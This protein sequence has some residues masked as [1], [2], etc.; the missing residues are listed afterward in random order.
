MGAYK[1]HMRTEHRKIYSQDLLNNLFKHPYTRIEYVVDELGVGRQAAGRYL[2]Q[3]AETGLIEKVSK[4]VN[5]Y[6][7]NV[8]LVELLTNGYDN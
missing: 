3:L 8:P 4:G 5:N 7:I 6:Y 1:T 2:D